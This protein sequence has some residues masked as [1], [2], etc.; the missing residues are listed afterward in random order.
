MSDRQLT[1]GESVPEDDS[2]KEIEQSTGMQRSYVV[3]TPEERAKGFV[4]PLRHSY[5]HAYP[6][7]TDRKVGCGVETRMGAAIAETYARNPRFYN[8]TFCVGCKS[9]FPLNEFIWDGGGELNGEPMDPDLQEAW[10]IE[11]RAKRG[12]EANERRVRRIAEL[13]REL[14]ELETTN[15]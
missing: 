10:L 4:K 8:G 14:A 3:L 5:I 15:G 7:E 9:H 12:N 2:H 6:S 11:S 1:S 13:K